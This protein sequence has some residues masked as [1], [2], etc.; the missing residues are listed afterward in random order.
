MNRILYKKNVKEITDLIAG[1]LTVAIVLFLAWLIFYSEPAKE[2][3]F[4]FGDDDVLQDVWY[5]ESSP[6]DRKA[7][8]D[9]L[10]ATECLD[11]G[12]CRLTVPFPVDK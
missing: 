12:L 6:S 5:Y 7:I 8:L 4:I 1:V 11:A 3:E 10:T 2:Q 9:G